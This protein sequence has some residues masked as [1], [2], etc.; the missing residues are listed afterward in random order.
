MHLPFSRKIIFLLLIFV[1]GFVLTRNVFAYSTKGNYQETFEQ[2][3]Y[4]TTQINQPSFTNETVQSIIAGLNN[5]IV[6]CFTESCQQV[7]GAQTQGAVGG[8][9][10]LIA[11]MYANPPASG[12]QYL[13]DLGKNL[14]IVK[15]AYAQTGTGWTGLQPIL[16]IWK[17]FRNIAYLFFTIIFIVIGFAIMFRVKIS[18]QAIVTIQS[19]IPRIVIAL[20]LVT[21]S[22]AIAGFL[23]DLM[24]VIILLGISVLGSTNLPSVSNTG[25]LQRIFTQEGF[26]GVI[27]AAFGLGPWAPMMVIGGI[28]GGILGGLFTWNPVGVAIGIAVGGGLFGL[29]LAVIILYV[30]FK[31]LIELIKAYISILL[32]IIF[33]P[34]QIALDAIPGQSGF[35][36]WLRNLVAN[37]AV[38]PAVAIFLVIARMLT[39]LKTEELWTPPMTVGAN[40]VAA[41]IGFGMLLV[42]SKVP[43]IVKNAFGLKPFPYGTAIG[44]ALGPIAYPTRMIKAGA[45]KKFGEFAAGE[46]G[47]IA[48]GLPGRIMGR[49]RP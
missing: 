46:G 47:R 49:F 4:G 1:F 25:D 40:M 8:I 41:L 10:N 5:Q 30:L 23:I 32:L 6:G 16:P 28:I 37:I 15:P 29:I 31:L 44:E 17:A 20:I 38:F 48:T 2:S 11:A 18:P 21:F 19:A 3:V 26:T 24:Y 13:A 34:L 14:G 27:G 12:V 36:S 35:G 33:A 9:S 45:E 39:G 7:Q 42:V 22:Y 43:E